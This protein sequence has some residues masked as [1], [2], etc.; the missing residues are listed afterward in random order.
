MQSNRKE[1]LCGIPV[2]PGV[3][4]SVS[5]AGTFP[6]LIRG[7]LGGAFH[8]MTGKPRR[9]CPTHTAM[10]VEHDGKL[11]I[12]DTVSPASRLTE[13]EDYEYDIASGERWNLELFA[14]AGMDRWTME[15]ASAWWMVHVLNSPY[16]W[17]AF[18]RLTLKALF[19]DWCASAAG[20]EWAHWCT[21]GVM[22]A[23][24]EGAKADIFHNLNPTPL[25]TIKRYTEGK[26]QKLNP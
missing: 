7:A 21:E 11:W 23:Y 9:N 17:P 15:R 16:D 20:L 22:R 14:P 25:T 3:I 4:V 24:R 13:L 10:I 18:G 12:G 19:G 6:L 1:T 26:L 2:W 8:R 5:N